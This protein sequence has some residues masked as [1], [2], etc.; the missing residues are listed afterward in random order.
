MLERL[1]RMGFRVQLYEA[2]SDVG[3]VWHW[4]RYPGARVDS[5]SYTYGFAF[6]DEL[7]RE[8]EWRELFAAQPE[9]RRYLRHVVD[10]FDL[11]RHMR[12]NTRVSAASYDSAR[13]CWNVE[14]DSGDRLRAYSAAG[15]SRRTVETA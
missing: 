14:T 3:G 7:T 6:S 1:L 12:F 15:M 9:I 2:G 8:W 10:R 4:N 13:R 11:R 5:E